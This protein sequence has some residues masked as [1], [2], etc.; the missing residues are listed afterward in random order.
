MDGSVNRTREI[1]NEFVDSIDVP[2]GRRQVQQEAVRMQ[3][4]Q[5]RMRTSKTD[6]ER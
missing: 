5:H 3:E 6:Q 2:A 1:H 4:R